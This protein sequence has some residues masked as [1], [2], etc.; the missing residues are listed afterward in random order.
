MQFSCHRLTLT[1]TFSLALPGCL[2]AG[3]PTIDFT[4][5][6]KMRIDTI[7]FFFVMYLL[8]AWGVKWFWND[9]RSTFPKMPK[10]SYRRALGLLTIWALLFVVVLTMISGAREL[11][12]PGA[13]ERS[14]A[15]YKLVEP[16]STEAKR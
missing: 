7:S 14:G 9:L 8:I 2:L 11:L 16:T 5:I 15:T 3:M 12:T 4:D 6:A 1:L 13:W 10:I